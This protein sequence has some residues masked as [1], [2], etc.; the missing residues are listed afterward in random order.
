MFNT[1]LEHRNIVYRENQAFVSEHHIH[2]L[3][4]LLFQSIEQCCKTDDGL[5]SC[6]SP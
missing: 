4:C 1:T 2:Y 6:K 3:F 5:S